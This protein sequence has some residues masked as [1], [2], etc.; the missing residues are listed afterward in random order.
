MELLGHLAA[1]SYS[2]GSKHPYVSHTAVLLVLALFRLCAKLLCHGAALAS[3][4]VCVAFSSVLCPTN[5]F[6]F[7]HC[8]SFAVYFCSI[9]FAIFKT[10]HSFL[11]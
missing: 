3:Y 2:E 10:D 6:T 11:L 4:I 1:A 7:L 5:A 8:K 9:R